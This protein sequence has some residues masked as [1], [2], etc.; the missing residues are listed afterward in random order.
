MRRSFF[1][2]CSWLLLSIA[3]STAALESTGWA[4]EIGPENGAVS[5]TVSAQE[6]EYS[7][8]ATSPDT[9]A[10]DASQEIQNQDAQQL[11]ESAHST[12]T[13][14]KN[15]INEYFKD[16]P[17]LNDVKC[18]AFIKVLDTERILYSYHGSEPLV[19]ASNM[20]IVTTA[21][22]LDLLG[23]EYRYQTELWGAPV[24]DK[25]V[26]SGDLYLRGNGDPTNTPPYWQT[27]T[28]MYE[29]LADKLQAEG[30]REILGDL[31][32]DDSLFDREYYPQ[33]WADHYHLDSYSAPVSGLSLNG[34]M[35]E[36]RING[37]GATA[38]P[39]N[40]YFKIAYSSEGAADTAVERKRNSNTITVHGPLSTV[41]REITVDNPP[42][43]A[44][45]AFAHILAQRGIRI[46]GKVRLIRPIG[47]PAAV[48]GMYKYASIDS[49][50]L[51]ELIT[52]INQQSDNFLAEH[53]FK[54]IGA[55][56]YGRGN[57]QT[58]ENSI[59]RFMNANGIDAEGLHMVDGCGLSKQNTITPSQIA[60]TLTVMAHHR[61]ADIFRESLASNEHGTLRYRIPGTDVHGK[62]GT[63]DSDT[64]LSGY[65]TNASGQVII[66]S[67]LFNDIKDIGIGVDI[68]NRI[69]TM[70]A[71]YPDR[72]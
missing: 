57:A 12:A 56:S 2:T 52:E 19:P 1:K 68:Q 16:N 39:D 46:D 32:A 7:D 54:T 61:Y 37:T 71:Q 72:L 67:M 51:K 27:P 25:G 24:S 11:P 65:V 60:D 18:G 35:V 48:T 10:A 23:P 26:I 42:L 58:S 31:V 63:L 20:K 38:Y 47:E 69:V 50:P 45:S 15:A 14:L 29:Q 17:A 34:N 3:L 36:V 33:G 55:Y 41:N 22:A 59:R 21:T 43:F 30:V 49:P 66:F 9:G 40:N 5:E 62:T 53:L 8:D 6:T 44:I 64:S 4:Q 28:A 13:D 70:L